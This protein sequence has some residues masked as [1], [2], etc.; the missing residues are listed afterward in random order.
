MEIVRQRSEELIERYAIQTKIDAPIIDLLT[1]V[2]REMRQG[3]SADGVSLKAPST[4]LSTAEAIGV[5]LDAALSARFFGNGKVTPETV[6]KNL[7]GSIVKEDLAD[8]K[9]LQEYVVLVAKKRASSNK[10]WK[11][12]HDA[13]SKSIR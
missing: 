6:A 5:A 1:T 2:F 11:A 10:T 4:T 3:K 12:F 7:V 9:V 8:L 13:A